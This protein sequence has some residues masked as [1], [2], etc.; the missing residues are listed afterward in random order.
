MTADHNPETPEL[1]RAAAQRHQGSWWE[2]WAIWSAERAGAKVE[3]PP[4]GSEQ[5]P[6]LG[7]GPGE[8]VRT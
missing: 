6:V 3:P 2:D 5:H 8:Y 7:D 1:W 4:T